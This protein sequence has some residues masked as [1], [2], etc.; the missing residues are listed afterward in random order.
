MGNRATIEVTNSKY[1]EWQETPCYIYVHWDGS[2][3]TVT[4]LVKGASSNMRKS[5][6]SYATSRL[7]AEICNHIEGGLSVGVL[8]A[9]EINK[10]K[11]DNG[12]YVIDM[13]NGHIKNNG[14]L[15]TNNI[16]FGDF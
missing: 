8:P 16:E 11:W 4:Q 14:K 1:S 10:E 15:V 3:D 7:I 9:T 5:D 12:H 2:P 13:N 6:V